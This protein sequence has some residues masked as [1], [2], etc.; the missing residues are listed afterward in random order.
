MFKNSD[1]GPDSTQ[2]L[3]PRRRL[4]SNPEIQLMCKGPSFPAKMRK[5]EHLNVSETLAFA[6]EWRRSCGKFLSCT[7]F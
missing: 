6:P 5:M 7:R 1:L 4:E 3:R 2:V